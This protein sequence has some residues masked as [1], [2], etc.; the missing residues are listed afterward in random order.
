MRAA[1]LKLHNPAVHYGAVAASDTRGDVINEDAL[2][3]VRRGFVAVIVSVPTLC[4]MVVA[5]LLACIAA[6]AWTAG[7]R[8]RARM[9]A[10]GSAVCLLALQ[11]GAFLAAVV[12][13]GRGP[14][15]LP[16]RLLTTSERGASWLRRA[17]LRCAAGRFSGRLTVSFAGLLWLWLVL[18]IDFLH[19]GESEDGDVERARLARTM[20]PLWL[21]WALLVASLAI[22]CRRHH[23]HTYRLEPLQLVGAGLCVVSCGLYALATLA[24]VGAPFAERQSRLRSLPPAYSGAAAVL[25][26][27]A[28]AGALHLAFERHAR[29]LARSRGH[30]TPLP[31]ARTPQGYWAPTGTGESF[32]FLLGSF[33]R[34]APSFA[35][36]PSLLSVATAC[37]DRICAH[38]NGDAR[39][40]SPADTTWFMVN[41]TVCAKCSDYYYAGHRGDDADDEDVD[42]VYPP[43]LAVAAPLLNDVTPTTLLRGNQPAQ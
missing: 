13:K 20:S 30:G 14:S 18:V 36:Q 12:L 39:V 17:W 16:A 23:N 31:L 2:P 11:T 19:H 43:A 34:C 5:Q 33:E 7:N 10:S 9:I 42:L 3:L 26:T 29:Q 15:E 41:C 25:A 21:A 8:H 35:Y 40:L 28:A 4:V 38:C 24:W 27:T 32:W 1:S 22:V 6:V 37:S